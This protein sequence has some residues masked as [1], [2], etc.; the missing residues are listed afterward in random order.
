MLI[1]SNGS[2]GLSV[3]SVW[4]MALLKGGY[5]LQGEWLLSGPW[6]DSP[7]T[8]TLPGDVLSTLVDHSLL[9][10]PYVG[11]NEFVAREIASHSWKLSRDFDLPPDFDSIDVILHIDRLDTAATV[12]LNGETILQAQNSFRHYQIGISAEQLKPANRLEILFESN[13]EVANRLQEQMPFFIPWHAGNSPIPNGNMLRKSQCDFG[14]DWNVALAP[15]GQYGALMLKPQRRLIVEATTFSQQHLE[16]GS[17]ELIAKLHVKCLES[18]DYAVELAVASC[19]ERAEYTLDPGSS[20]LIVVCTVNTP[21]LWWPAGMGEQHLYDVELRCDGQAQHY[22][23]GLRKIELIQEADEQAGVASH[24]PAISGDGLPHCAGR[25]FRFRVNGIDMF[26]RGANW[27]PADALPGRRSDKKTAALLGS[28]VAAN[29]N[30][31]RVWGG[32]QYESDEFYRECDR[33]GLMIWQDCMFACNLYPSTDDFL[34]EVREELLWQASRLSSHACIA[35]W[36]GDNELV[37]A[38][39]WFEAST[40]DRDRYLVNYDR[41]NRTVEQ[42]LKARLGGLNWWPSSPSAGFLDF[43]DAWHSDSS[44]DMHYWSVWHEGKDFSDYRNVRPR[45]CSEFGFQSL[46]SMHIIKTFAN[47][48]ELGINSPVMESHQKNAGGNARITETLMRYF[49]FP[50][51]FAN[52][53][54]LSQVQQAMAIRTAVDYWRSLKPHCMGTLYWQLNDTWPVASWSSLDYGGNWKALHYAIKR[55]YRPLVVIA[56][57]SQST[58]EIEFVAINDTPDNENIAVRID[59]ID[60]L[61][62]ILG[63]ENCQVEVSTARGNSFLTLSTD[64][65]SGVAAVTYSWTRT[66]ESGAGFEEKETLLL[67]TAKTVEWPDPELYLSQVAPGSVNAETMALEPALL[68]ERL[69]VSSDREDVNFA[70]PILLRLE[71]HAAAHYVVIEANVSGIFSNNLFFMPARTSMLVAF[72][73]F[74]ESVPVSGAMSSSS[75]AIEFEVRDLYA[76]YN[77][78]HNATNRQVIAEAL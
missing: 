32:G 78:N 53:V 58:R 37:G 57:E 9:E 13:P 3:K 11:R 74:L 71:C 47:D 70:N 36:C 73:P 51:D 49:R 23:I 69:A 61:G 28:A 15:V 38:L 64:S 56:L 54:Y 21:S 1:Q 5:N 65:F 22:K 29:M 34:E 44:G 6:L 68:E 14:W 43:A 25:G 75:A 26:A 67:R 12:I 50:V 52:L 41:L 7:V 66:G 42:T 16:D 72:Y 48:S 20:E 4:M 40:N 24:S 35:L 62:E 60:T 10:D 18:G 2:S 77:T 39:N 31:L 76:S 46:P 27:I 63:S 55:V 45:F 19:L 33:L 30:M 59:F 17:V 8:M